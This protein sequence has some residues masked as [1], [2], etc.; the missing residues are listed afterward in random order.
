MKIMI[1]VLLLL[2]A[3]TALSYA[4]SAT[5]LERYREA[6]AHY[7]KAEYREAVQIFKE[8]IDEGYV[9]YDLYYNLGNAAYKNGDLGT[10]VLSYERALTLDPGNENVTHNLNVVRARLRDRVEPMPL[11][12]FV[13]WWN[14][15]KDSHSPNIFF[16]W[17]L[18]FLF[19]LAAAVFVFF[20]YRQLILRRIA[21]IAGILFFTVFASALTLTITRTEELD[22]HRSAVIMTTEVTVR[23]TPDATGVESFIVHE[24]LKVVILESKNEFYRI[25]LADGKSG[26][27][28]RTALAR[29]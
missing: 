13:K 9:N 15:I 6:V 28:E 21:L 2:I 18:V 3:A 16:S 1:R 22:A 20:G 4:Q 27:V 7:K 19:L 26:W 12:F 11:L 25:R 14:D 10:S 23:S 29:I 24:G 5:P 8:L 17:S